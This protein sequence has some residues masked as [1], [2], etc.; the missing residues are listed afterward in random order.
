MYFVELFFGDGDD[1][2]I[3]SK[4]FKT[5]KKARDYAR[6]AASNISAIHHATIYY[7]SGE[8]YLVLNAKKGSE[9]IAAD[10]VSEI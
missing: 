3:P 10:T 9:Q 2:Y 4:K 6:D 5:L 7:S 8:K 1:S